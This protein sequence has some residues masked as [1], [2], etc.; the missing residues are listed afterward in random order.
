LAEQVSGIDLIIGGHTHTS[1]SEPQIINGVRIVQAKNKGAY[2]GK[3][4]ITN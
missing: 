4:V 1:L 3:I 2:L